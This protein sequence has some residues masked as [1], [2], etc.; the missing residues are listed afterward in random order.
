MWTSELDRLSGYRL[1]G[2]SA[3]PRTII[4]NVHRRS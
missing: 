3:A 2:T 1:P 4:G